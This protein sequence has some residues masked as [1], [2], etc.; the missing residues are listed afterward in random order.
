MTP[1]EAAQLER[2]SRRLEALAL[3]NRYQQGEI[4]RETYDLLV[5]D[6]GKNDDDLTRTR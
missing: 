5:S 4:S 3:W 1:T 2:E 6:I